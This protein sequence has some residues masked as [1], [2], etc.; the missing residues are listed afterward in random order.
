MVWPIGQPA[1]ERYETAL[2]SRELWMEFAAGSGLPVRECGSIHVAR[3]ED[4]FA[5]VEEFAGQAERLGYQ[6]SSLLTG[7]EVRARTPAAREDGL[8]G[9]LWSGT[10]LCVDP[11]EVLRVLPAWLSEKY[12]ID[13]RFGTAVV[14]ADAEG[15]VTARGE[16]IASDVVLVC[17]GSDFESL[18]PETYATSGLQRCKLQMFRTRP[19]PGNWRIGP[20]VASGLTLRH[21]ENFAVCPSLLRL[22]ER[23]AAENPLL[24]RYGI[25]VMAAQNDLGEVVLG[26]SHVYDDV[27]APGE[28]A[29]IESLVLAELRELLDLPDWRLSERWHGVYAKNPGAASFTAEP[30]PGVHVT[31]GL[32]GAGMT[33]SFGVAERRVHDILG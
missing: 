9:G 10:E 8:L 12:G 17:T 14:A 29:E 25:H 21:Y 30:A 33:M 28:D 31:T 32:G 2:R 22:R 15:V 27:F 5:V 26:D 13:V 18:F 11:R 3:R 4:E 19:Q 24:D 16:R 7:D 1:G 6:G 20:H 23:I